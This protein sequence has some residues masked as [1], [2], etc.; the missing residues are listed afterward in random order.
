M[1]TDGA[2]VF[3]RACSA[4]GAPVSTDLFARF[5][6]CEPI[7]QALTRRAFILIVVCFV[8]ELRTVEQTAGFVA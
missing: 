3:D 2:F 6:S 1:F 8:V 4:C 5:G 7:D